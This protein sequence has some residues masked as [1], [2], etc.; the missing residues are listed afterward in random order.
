MQTPIWLTIL[1]SL[2]SGIA[3][4]AV[5]TYV[6]LRNER[7]KQKLRIFEELL[8][9]RHGLTLAGGTEAHDRF[10]RALN[11]SFAIFYQSKSVVEAIQDFKKY[12]E[13]TADNVTQLLRSISED[14]KIDT[15]YLDDDFFDEPFT[16]G[17]I[18]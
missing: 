16:P 13:R 3:A 7:R 6:Y 5:S 15:S 1:L 12:K 2:F 18:K 4:Y 14:L 9:N 11:A 17:S 10:I 8:G